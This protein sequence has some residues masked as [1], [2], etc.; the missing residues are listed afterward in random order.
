MLRLLAEYM[1]EKIKDSN[2]YK[3]LYEFCTYLS[4]VILIKKNVY[5]ARR[6]VFRLK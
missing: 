1:Y 2:G 5:H 6:N 4:T 3:H